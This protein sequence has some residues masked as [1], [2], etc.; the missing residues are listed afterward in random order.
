M[1]SFLRFLQSYPIFQETKK[2]EKSKIEER[3]KK[4]EVKA[5]TETSES[6]SIEREGKKVKEIK[7]LQEFL[8]GV[9]KGTDVKL[10]AWA[11]NLLD[12]EVISDKDLEKAREVGFEKKSSIITRAEEAKPPVYR[13]LKIKPKGLEEVEK[14]P[15]AGERLRSHY[16]KLKEAQSTLKGISEMVEKATR[17]FQDSVIKIKKEFGELP[18]MT[19]AK[20]RLESI[21]NIIKESEAKTMDLGTAYLALM[22]KEKPLFKPS[23]KWKIEK[24]LEKYGK[25]AEEYLAAASSAASLLAGISVDEELI[26]FPHKLSSIDK[27]GGVGE[28]LEALNKLFNSLKGY[29]KKIS[30]VKEDVGEL[31][32]VLASLGKKDVSL[33]ELKKQYEQLIDEE[34]EMLVYTEKFNQKRYEQIQKEK[35]KIVQTIRQLSPKTAQDKKSGL[36]FEITNSEEAEGAIEE[37][38]TNLRRLL[39]FDVSVRIG[40]LNDIKQAIDDIIDYYTRTQKR[41]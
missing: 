31:L 3:V 4:T 18:A 26:E 34:A 30:E 38:A 5:S 12:R 37:T 28:I 40:E 22:T 2:E 7:G 6:K 27:L 19:E 15:I 25:E 24:L 9:F 1:N 23:D 35:D 14:A 36:I 17:E 20:S 33:S 39:D 10:A 11:R 32:P 29:T 41:K 16:E 21:A 8:E 13:E